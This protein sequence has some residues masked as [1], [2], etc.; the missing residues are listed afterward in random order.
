MRAAEAVPDG[1]P[2]DLSEALAGA[3]V[4]ESRLVESLSAI[5][6]RQRVSVEKDDLAGVDESVFAAQRVFRTLGEARRYRRSLLELAAGDGNIPL[7][8]LDTALGRG[9]TPALG[10]ARDGLRDAA[11]RLERQLDRNRHL[12]RAAMAAGDHLLR[13]LGEPVA[14]TGLYSPQG[15]A[16]GASGPPLL[17]NR[18][19]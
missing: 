17:L 11:R 6:E 4:T 2:R 16:G 14:P 12:L 9:M 1:G 15:A 7:G 5:L 18:R 10:A 13:A 8:E 3:L 19:I